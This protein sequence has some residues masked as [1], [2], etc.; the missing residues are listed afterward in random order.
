MYGKTMNDTLALIGLPCKPL[1]VVTDLCW[2]SLHREKCA[3]ELVV[4]FRPLLAASTDSCQ[5]GR[6]SQFLLDQPS[7]IDSCLVF[8]NWTGL[9]L[10]IPV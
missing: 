7:A 5:F 9:M 4:V 2:S 1:L 6:T 3:K 10:A 8:V